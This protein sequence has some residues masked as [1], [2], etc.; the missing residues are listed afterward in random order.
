MCVCVRMLFCGFFVKEI[1]NRNMH[2]LN[3]R[4]YG[5]R[6]YTYVRVQFEI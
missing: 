3:E 5:I 6:V 4:V 1:K 2:I